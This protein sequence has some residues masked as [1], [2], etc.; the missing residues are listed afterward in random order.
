MN[1]IRSSKCAGGE[2]A[3][4]AWRRAADCDGGSCVEVTFDHTG[5]P[6][7]SHGYVVGVRN[8]TSPADVI[9]F[10][11]DEWEAF[12]DGVRNAEFDI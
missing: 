4:V 3:E 7:D 10:T 9:W 6:E 5:H 8:S 2:C 11:A 12:C 1:W